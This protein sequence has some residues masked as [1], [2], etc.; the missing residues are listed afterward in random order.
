MIGALPEKRSRTATPPTIHFDAGHF[1]AGRFD[2]GLSGELHHHWP[3]DF[4]AALIFSTTEPMSD[5][6]EVYSPSGS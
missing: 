5:R 1:D 6:P 2:A 4:N 3:M